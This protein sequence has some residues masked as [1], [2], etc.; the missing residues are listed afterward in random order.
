[1]AAAAAALAR[2]LDPDAV[3][4]GAARRSP[5]CRTGSRRWRERGGVLYVNDSKAT[6]V[7]AAAAAHRAFDGGVHVILGGSL[8]GGGFAGLARGRRARAAG[9]CYLIGEAAE[10][11]ARG[12]RRRG[13]AL[14]ALRRPR[15][16]PSRRPRAAA[17]PGE[18]VLLA[19]ACAS[20]DQ[21]A[22]FEERGEHFRAWQARGASMIRRRA[23][24]AGS[25]GSPPRDAARA[26]PRPRVLDAL[27][28]D[29][30]PDRRRRGDGL[31]AR[32]R[33][34]RCSRHRRHRRTT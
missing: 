15:G 10:R 30:V 19:P 25:D 8:K 2:G 26:K 18:M 13:V 12:P 22:D 16:A 6:N 24:K 29:A 31:L 23:S 34:S 32:A 17:R 4:A 27:H 1:M 7:A 14:R 9:A 33:P 3:R 11:L 28:G 21:Y 20:F 5:A